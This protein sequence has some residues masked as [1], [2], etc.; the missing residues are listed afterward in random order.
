MDRYRG[1]LQFWHDPH[2]VI[3]S[4]VGFDLIRPEWRDV[5]RPDRTLARLQLVDQL[6]YLPEDLLAKVDRASMA[7]ALEVRVPLLDHRVVEFAARLPSSWRWNRSGSKALLRK[8]LY[9]YVPPALVDRPKMG[10]SVPHA[11][12]LQTDLRN[13]ADDL[14]SPRSLSETGDWNTV[15]IQKRWKEHC[16]GTHRWH[17]QIWPILLYQSWARRWI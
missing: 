12:W 4:P 9:R 7:V 11:E 5:G 14:L 3:S 16:A 15:T 6:T 10:F 1:Y 17:Y 2:D 8:V 13:W